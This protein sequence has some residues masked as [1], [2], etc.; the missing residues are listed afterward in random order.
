MVLHGSLA[1]ETPE[2]YL[3][4]ISA[5]A[6][7]ATTTDDI[8]TLGGIWSELVFMRERLDA[9]SARAARL[10]L[11][12]WLLE[13]PDMRRE[14]FSI[15]ATRAE[16][17]GDAAQA[18]RLG[19]VSSSIGRMEIALLHDDPSRALDE[20]ATHEKERASL[21]A[22]LGSSPDGF[23]DGIESAQATAWLLLAARASVDQATVDR[24]RKLACTP[25]H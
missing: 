24:F 23:L 17:A 4:E 20:L 3:A 9:P 12:D 1:R 16:L 25:R 6:S 13:R 21:I 11:H 5:L 22:N 10:R 7:R 2:G 8:L 19:P 14:L 15:N 18:A